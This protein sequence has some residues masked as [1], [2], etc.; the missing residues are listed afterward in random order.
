M[1]WE[2]TPSQ[3]ELPE[4]RAISD[5]TWGLWNRDRDAAPSLQHITKLMSINVV[6]DDTVA[7]IKQAL[8]S[9]EPS[10]GQER[11]TTAP[12]WPGIEFSTADEAGQALLGKEP[13]SNSRYGIYYFRHTERMLNGDSGSQNG[14][15]SAYFLAQHKNQLGGNKYIDKITIVGAGNDDGGS[16]NMIFWVKDAPNP[17]VPPE[18]EMEA[19]GKSAVDASLS[20]VVHRG[21]NDRSFLRSHIFRAKL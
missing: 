15:G 6:N 8:W 2:R 13:Q 4:L 11:I 5:L 16:P 9:K 19:S 7:I 20:Q 10:P 3:D 18:T 14:I 1:L 21:V 12:K 17:P